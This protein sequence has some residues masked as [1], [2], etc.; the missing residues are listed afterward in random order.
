M[1]ITIIGSGSIFFTRSII[2]TMMEFPSFAGTEL[3]LVD[4][5]DYRC[6]QMGLFAQKALKE[7]GVD[8]TSTHTTDRREVLAGSDYVILTCAKRNAHHRGFGSH[9]AENYGILEGSGD[10]AGP[11]CVSRTIRAVP[12]IL[13]IARDIEELCPDAWVLNMVNP[14]NIIGTVLDRFTKLK[15][16]SF[17]D[18]MY[19]SKERADDWNLDVKV[20]RYAGIDV[21][22][23]FENFDRFEMPI[24]GINHCVWMTGL[25]LDGKDIWLRFKEGLKR[26]A[27]QKGTSSDAFCEWQLTEMFDAF[28]TV[29][30]HT[31]EYSR[32]FQGKGSD[33]SRDYVIKPWQLNS[34]V[35]WTREVWREIASCNAG[36]S[37]VAHVL[38]DQ[39]ID[40]LAYVIDSMNR[41][42]N[43]KFPVNVRN[44]GRISNLPDD[45]LV[46]SF[47]SFDHEGAHVGKLPSLP[48]GVLGLVQQVVDY[49]ELCIEAAMSGGDYAMVVRAVATDPIVMS[50]SDAKSVAHDIMASADEDLPPE[51]DAY[52]ACKD[53]ADRFYLPM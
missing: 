20:P 39:R 40:M 41:D 6:E 19:F 17:C 26:E 43:Y 31:K 13:A 42:L 9:I 44:E 12:E 46:E 24:S 36:E 21:S 45:I 48:R 29:I 18:G 50:L 51:W 1:K 49:Q 4:I 10:T 34:R 33:P 53:Y 16:Y 8:V 11:G 5:D 38:R 32:Y 28:P 30:G 3:A 25:K 14:T 52:W 23:N 2:K 15:G 7:A 27:H 22:P 37:T 35:R 47:G